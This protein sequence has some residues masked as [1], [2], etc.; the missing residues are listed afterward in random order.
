MHICCSVCLRYECKCNL[1]VVVE[2]REII[3]MWHDD[4]TR[5]KEWWLGGHLEGCMRSR[6]LWQNYNELWWIRE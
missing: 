1:I 4:N 3:G 5:G 6:V 2:G